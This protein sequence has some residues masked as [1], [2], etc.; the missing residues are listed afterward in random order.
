MTP[1]NNI[2]PCLTY[3]HPYY[4][5]YNQNNLKYYKPPYNLY[6]NNQIP[7]YNTLQKPPEP[8]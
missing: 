8:I 1:Y 6:Y 7:Y 2:P 4:A 5:M 3:L